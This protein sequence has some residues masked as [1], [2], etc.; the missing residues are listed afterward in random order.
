M[1]RV[2]LAFATLLLTSGCAHK[3][4]FQ[5]MDGSGGSGTASRGSGSGDIEATIN[6]KIYRGR[7]SA[8]TQGSMG[9]GTLLAGGQ[10]ATAQTAMIGGSSGV[11]ILRSADGSAMRCEFVYSGLSSGGYGVCQDREGK[12]YDMLIG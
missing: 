12:R 7:W 11:A 5:A 8:A 9:F 2:A 10:M 4:T 1:R 3:L 6:G